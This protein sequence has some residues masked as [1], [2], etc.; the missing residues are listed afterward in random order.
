MVTS[1]SEQIFD[2]ACVG[3][4]C[5]DI[6]PQIPDVGYTQIDEIF[7]P[8]KLINVDDADVS[9]GGPVANTGLVLAKLGARIAFI[10]KVGDDD[11]GRIIRQRL[12]GQGDIRG[13]K[14][15]QNRGS[16]YSIVLAPP[17]IDRM[18]LHNPG[19]NDIFTSADINYNLVRKAKIF[20]FGYPPI[21]KATFE[22]EGSELIRIFREAKKCGVTTALDFSLPD[23]NS[24][25]GKVDWRQLLKHVLPYVDIFLPSIEEAF[26]VLDPQGFMIAHKSHGGVNLIEKLEPALFS[27]LAAEFLRMGCKMAAL[28]AAHRGIY[29]RTAVESRIIEMGACKPAQS[30]A[31]ASRELWC[32]AF[33]IYK[34]A[35]AT[36]AGD[37]AI[38]GFYMALLNGETLE[39]ALKIAC[40]VGYQN[41]HELDAVSGVRSWKE[42][43]A[44]LDEGSLK[45]HPFHID[46]TGWYWDKK[47]ELWFGPHDRMIIK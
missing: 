16:S 36:G 1:D 18:F 44:L 38:A 21:M 35:S 37:A 34:I 13:L 12:E 10:A 28:K 24:Q 3:H 5:L 29:F 11:F 30:D 7:R 9:T 46:S 8:G 14:I 20:H 22:N 39:R 42:T 43:I 15:E 19:T 26:Y 45:H 6:I 27:E 41:L 32:P 33:Q 4:I 47:L 2:V 31:W 23:P 40:C 17:G 25:S